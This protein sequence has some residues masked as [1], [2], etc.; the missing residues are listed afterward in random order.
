MI[1]KIFN[2]ITLGTKPVYEK[3]LNF[4]RIVNEFRNKLLR[5]QNLARRLTEE[6]K[7]EHQLLSTLK[8]FN[9][10]D[11]SIQKISLSESDLDQFYNKLNNYDFSFMLFKE[12]YKKYIQNLNRFNPKAENKNFDL[13]MLSQVLKDDPLHPLKPFDVLTYN[14]KWKVKWSVKIYIWYLGKK[15]KNQQ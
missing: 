5:T 4:Y 10:I 8:H 3:H 11:L 9:V 15:N 14:L 13:F 12:Y 7:S 6:E 1:D 2:I